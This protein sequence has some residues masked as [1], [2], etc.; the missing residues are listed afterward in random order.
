VIV[1]FSPFL[2][3]FHLQ[4]AFIHPPILMKDRMGSKK[5][6]EAIRKKTLSAR[7]PALNHLSEFVLT[8]Q[9]IR[10]EF[11]NRAKSSLVAI[12]K[13]SLVRVICLSLLDSIKIRLVSSLLTTTIMT[14]EM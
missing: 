6:S 12:A 2:L 8:N 1:D 9:G 10:A 4:N 5:A 13:F 14:E 7:P 3:A 11:T